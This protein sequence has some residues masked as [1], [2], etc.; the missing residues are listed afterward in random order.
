[1]DIKFGN[2]YEHPTYG[3]FEIVGS[4]E[5]VIAGHLAWKVKFSTGVY[6][7]RVVTMA[8]VAVNKSKLLNGDLEL[9]LTKC[10]LTFKQ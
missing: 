2:V 3:I 5:G 10:E 7:G 4:I 8:D 6:K 9:D 1:M